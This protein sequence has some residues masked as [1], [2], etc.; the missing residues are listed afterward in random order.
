MADLDLSQDEADQLIS[1]EKQ[2]IDEKTRLFE[3]GAQFSIPLT[4]ADK[5]E[6]YS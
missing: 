5:R 2:R 3:A 6:N 4:S 1:M